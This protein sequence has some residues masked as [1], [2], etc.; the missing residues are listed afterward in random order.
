VKSSAVAEP[1]VGTQ[2]TVIAV[3][4]QNDRDH[5]QLARAIDSR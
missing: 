5:A 2:K 4:D 1:A 3:A